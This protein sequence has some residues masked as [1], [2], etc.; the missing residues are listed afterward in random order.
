MQS[1]DLTVTIIMPFLSAPRH[2]WAYCTCR[3]S[4]TS[5]QWQWLRLPWALES[6]RGLPI[7]AGLHGEHLIGG[8]EGCECEC[9]CGGESNGAY[10]CMCQ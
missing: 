7:Q 4:Y 5:E 6:P 9:E 1:H 10:V 8:A 3:S 2:R